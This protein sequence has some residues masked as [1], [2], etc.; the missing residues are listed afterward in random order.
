[1][2]LLGVAYPILL[3]LVAGLAESL[4]LVGPWVAGALAVTVTLFTGGV[5]PAGEVAGLYLL[6]HLIEGNT[7]VPYVTYR[8]TRLNPLI[9]ILAIAVGGSVL[10]VVGAVLGV[11][12]AL[13]L[14]VLTLRVL[15]PGLRHLAGVAT[16]S[17]L[18]HPGVR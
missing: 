18:E 9:T 2:A 17:E 11:P 8:L 14:Q 10:G 15:V 13:A 6:I 4:P 5:L 7:L 1:M 16:R 3:A 12:I